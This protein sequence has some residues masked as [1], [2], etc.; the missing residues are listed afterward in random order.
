MQN[1]S[2][3]GSYIRHILTLLLGDKVRFQTDSEEVEQF[4]FNKSKTL[5]PVHYVWQSETKNKNVLLTILQQQNNKYYLPLVKL[6]C[7][8]LM[9]PLQKSHWSNCDTL[10]IYKP[11]L[12]KKKKNPAE[13]GFQ[14]RSETKMR[15]SVFSSGYRRGFLSASCF[16]I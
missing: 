5:L 9:N 2:I 16:V 11:I 15:S 6:C 14:I 12:R 10:I 8:L 7:W 4:D 3:V 13:F 1:M